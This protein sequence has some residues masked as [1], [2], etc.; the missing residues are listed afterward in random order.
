VAKAH[1]YGKR[2]VDSIADAY[3]NGVAWEIGNSIY[4]AH[5]FAAPIIGDIANKDV[6]IALI[7]QSCERALATGALI[8]TEKD[9][10]LAKLGGYFFDRTTSAADNSTDSRAGS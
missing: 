7:K 8:T 2:G 4:D 10:R 9:P 3:N 5:G 1:E 6:A